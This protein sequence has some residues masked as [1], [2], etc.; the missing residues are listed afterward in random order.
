MDRKTG[1]VALDFDGTLFFTQGS[2]DVAVKKLLNRTGMTRDEIRKLPKKV[3][4]KI[5]DLGYSRYR[6]RGV[7][8]KLL[9]KRIERL[10]KNNKIIVL[11][12]R[13]KKLR[14]HAE[15]LIKKHGI[16]VDGVY[17]RENVNGMD[18][19]W[20][21]NMMKRFSKDYTAISLYED[22]LENIEYI[23]KRLRFKNASYYLV[24]KR[25]I[26]KV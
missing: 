25:S 2:L 8:N 5:Y 1:L 7:P 4:G 6:S 20:K 13:S 23:R 12:A 15:W 11:T 14:G 22:K 26:R 24:T 19:E 3:K 9:I 17:H 18:E 16:T 10:R 21:L